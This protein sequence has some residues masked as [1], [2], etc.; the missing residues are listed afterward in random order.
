[1]LILGAG[2]GG[3]ATAQS[4]HAITRTAKIE[5]DIEIVLIDRNDFQLF[6]PELYEI[7][8]ADKH[9]QNV[10]VLRDSVT[11]DIRHAI[12]NKNIQFAIGAIEEINPN[13][14]WVR[15]HAA[16]Y[17]Y[18]TLVVALGSEPFYFG[19]E[20][21]EEHAI[22]FKSIDNA[23]RVRKTIHDRLAAGEQ[24]NMILCGAGPAGVEVGA[25]ALVSCKEYVESG[26]LT[27]TLVEG[28]DRVLPMFSE[29][30]S[31]KA[32]KRLKSIG[33]NIRTNFFIERATAHSVES[34][35]GEV[36]NGNLLVWT[37]GITGNRALQT[38]GLEL[39]KRGQLPV[40]QTM[41]SKVHESIFAIGDAAE[42]ICNG[43][44]VAQ[45]AHEAV[46]QAPIA[47]ENIVRRIAG[48]RAGDFIEY[49]PE[50]EGYVITMGGKHGIVILPGGRLLT[51]VL[52]WFARKYVDFR[53]F[54]SVLPLV[55]AVTLWIRGLR[56]MSK[57]D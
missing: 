28:K 6:T 52:G 51:G 24:V 10:N 49:S 17:S 5:Q 35:N 39:N 16:Q 44:P 21:M 13:E 42:C 36:L 11:V 30:L 34:T 50:D 32:Y 4:L 12:R 41:Q 15:T 2:F 9:I 38:M 31:Q 23:L 40:G 43:T 57:N 19:I 7:A 46:H 25:E 14:Q 53:H 47:A 33:M 20:G 3:L 18:D 48:N 29:E 26:Q 8:S 22:P 27:V 56:I 55:Q 45:T 37:G 1:M 54:R